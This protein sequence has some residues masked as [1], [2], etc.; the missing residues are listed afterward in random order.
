MIMP[1]NRPIRSLNDE[2]FAAY[3][4]GAASDAKSLVIAC[5]AAMRPEIAG[6]IADM[7]MIGGALLENAPGAAL[8]DGFFDRVSANLVGARPSEN[9]ASPTMSASEAEADSWMPAPL[10]DYLS[11]KGCVLKWRFAGPGISRAA[12]AEADNGERLY[13]LRAR[14]GSVLPEHSH[15]GEEWT[16]I[17]KGTYHTGEEG[18]IA[19]D[20]HRE[21][22]RCIHQPIVDQGE[23]CICLVA[24]EGR[25]KFHQPLLKLLQPFIGV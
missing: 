10:R 23:E 13:L 24:I 25:L 9:D 16:L 21:D 18:Y 19:G 2:W 7:E 4:A 3:V 1:H 20:L 22:E 11:Q 8:S 15:Q 17:L 6:K 5:Q 14:A 12:L